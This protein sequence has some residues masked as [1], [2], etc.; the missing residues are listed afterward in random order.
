MK[1]LQV[2][3]KYDFCYGRCRKNN[4]R[5]SSP[6]NTTAIINISEDLQT[7]R[8]CIWRNTIDTFKTV[9]TLSFSYLCSDSFWKTNILLFCVYVETN[10][11]KYIIKILLFISQLLSFDFGFKYLCVICWLSASSTYKGNIDRYT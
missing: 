2:W 9:F 10:Y 7:L 11:Q 5:L 6:R 4:L 3:I 8:Q 1:R